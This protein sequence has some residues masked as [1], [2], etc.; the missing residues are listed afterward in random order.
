MQL[1]E[2]EE[3]TNQTLVTNEEFTAD[4]INGLML[5]REL[6]DKGVE[7][8]AVTLLEDGVLIVNA[9]DPTTDQLALIAAAVASHTGGDFH[10][11]NQ[12]SPSTG[13]VSATDENLVEVAALDTGPLRAGAY[14]L[15]W[16]G[17]ACVSDEL[18]HAVA[19]STLTM[20]TNGGAQSERALS[21]VSGQSWGNIGGMQPVIL[22]DGESLQ[23]KLNVSRVAAA[24]GTPSD[25]Q[26]KM[27]RGQIFIRRA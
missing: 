1:S 27:Q 22:R 16:Y 4:S 8:E 5:F 7:V 9:N 25:S 3:K 20:G 14:L 18:D 6:E 2:V 26:A 11:C 21:C 10:E 23:F 15:I 13:I 24:T 19:V 12:V 17:E